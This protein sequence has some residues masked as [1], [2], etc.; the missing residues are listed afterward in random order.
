MAVHREED[1]DANVDVD[2]AVSTV[3]SRYTKHIIT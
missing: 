3:C 2:V 1:D